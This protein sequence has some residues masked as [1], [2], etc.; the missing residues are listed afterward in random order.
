VTNLFLVHV[1]DRPHDLQHDHRRLGLREAT[2]VRD[3]TKERAALAKLH[4]KVGTV[5]VF[6]ALMHL[7]D[8]RV[9]HHRHDRHLLPEV[10]QV[11]VLPPHDLYGSCGS[12][13]YVSATADA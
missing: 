9:V 7:D 6:K 8:V 4:D 5:I 13:D 1:V 2:R 10:V 3:A 12:L 11:R